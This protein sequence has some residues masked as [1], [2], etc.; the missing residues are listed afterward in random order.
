M[1]A[2]CGA[3]ILDAPALGEVGGGILTV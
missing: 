3:S 1:I 2:D